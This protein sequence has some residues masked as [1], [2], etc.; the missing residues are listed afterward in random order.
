MGNLTAVSYTSGSTGKPK[1]VMIKHQSLVNLVA[2]H[3]HEYEVT[4]TS[5]TTTMAGVGFDAFGW[6]IWP[7]LTAGASIYIIDDETRLSTSALSA[8]F[9]SRNITHSFISTALVPDFINTSRYKAGALKYLLTGGDK[10]SVL[11]L[12]GIN[13]ILANN[14]GP[15]ENTVV[16]TSCIVSQKDKIPP[17]GKPIRNT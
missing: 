3:N 9:I 17:I 15:T 11:S 2:W 16:T 14:Y 6:E 5:K 12:D 8:L 4:E 10:L 7:Y 1:G 13:Y